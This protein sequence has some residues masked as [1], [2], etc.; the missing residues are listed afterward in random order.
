MIINDCVLDVVNQYGGTMPSVVTLYDRS[1]YKHEGVITIGV[2][3][4]WAQGFTDAWNFQH[5]G[6][7][8]TRFPSHDGFNMGTG[9]QDFPFAIYSWAWY[10]NIVNRTL[11]GK[12]DTTLGRQ[13]LVNE[14][15]RIFL[16]LYDESANAYIGVGETAGITQSVFTFYAFTYDGSG[17]D[18][19][20]MIYKNGEAV[21]T[22]PSSGGAYVA[23][24]PSN[25]D[26]TLGC[27]LNNG[28]IEN[29]WSGYY[30]NTKVLHY[31]PNPGEIRAYYHSTKWLYGVPV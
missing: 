25:I 8:W 13:W 12:N 1:R 10:G 15:T 27:K 9:A 30:G 29:A 3:G 7:T 18:T 21:A 2:N 24:E 4:Q 14:S 11:I 28:A 26:L 19:G 17:A 31:L 22:T 6:T 5:F 20:I 16:Y 23:M